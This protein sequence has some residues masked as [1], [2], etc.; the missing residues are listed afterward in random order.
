M[1]HCKQ[2]DISSLCIHEK[3]NEKVLSQLPLP[4]WVVQ[5]LVISGVGMIIQQN[6]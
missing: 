4:S 2:N 6:R 3:E 5:D 1:E